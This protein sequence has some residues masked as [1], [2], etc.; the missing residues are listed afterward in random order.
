MGKLNILVK[1]RVVDEFYHEGK[2][3]I[4]GRK[5]SDYTIQYHNNS[6]NRVKVVLSVD[7]LNVISGDT[8][9]TR[10]YVVESWAT[11]NVPGWRKD[12]NNVA[13]FVFSSQRGSYNQHNDEGDARNIGVIG[14]MV[15]QERP[16]YI[17]NNLTIPVCGYHKD[18]G[19]DPWK[20]DTYNY[21]GSVARAASSKGNRFGDAEVRAGG[22]VGSTLGGQATFTATC[23]MAAQPQ[24]SAF[25]AEPMAAAVEV[26]NVG[27]GWGSNQHF[28]TH[29]VSY[30]FYDTTYETLTV[31][32][33][34]IR[35][36]RN[37]GIDIRYGKVKHD[38]NPFP[39]YK[40]G[41]PPPKYR[42][43]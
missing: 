14:A 38:P 39:K 35:G 32:Y 27:T 16:Q 34:D 28:A 8:D 17:W 40:D 33:D 15:F 31:Y 3:F 23:N 25:Y 29:E 20:Y 37:R 7:G 9:W 30:D 5:G 19:Y 36:L 26:N 43:R 10:G 1:N 18:T 42:Y 12:N 6:S 21:S 4:E 24:N 2:T 22:V 41:C 11:V 13:Q